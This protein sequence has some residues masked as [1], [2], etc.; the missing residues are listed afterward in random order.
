[1]FYNLIKLRRNRTIP[2]YFSV[3]W[4]VVSLSVCRLLKPFDIFRCLLGGTL[5]THS[6][7]WG[8][9]TT[10]GEAGGDLGVEPKGGTTFLKVGVQ[11][12]KQKKSPA[13][14]LAYLG[15]RETEHCAVFIIV[16]SG[17]VWRLNIYERAL[18]EIILI[19]LACVTTVARLKVQKVQF[20]TFWGQKPRAEVDFLEKGRSG[21]QQTLF[22]A[23][24]PP[25]CI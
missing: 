20:G 19:T 22:L 9:L 7:R 11:S 18:N 10:Q 4:S 2:T 14:H 3:V 13:P 23:W 1:V 21:S 6:V 12:R 16:S 5:L 8:S 24:K 17:P 15:G 25:K